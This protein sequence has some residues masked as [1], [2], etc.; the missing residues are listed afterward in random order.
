VTVVQVWLLVGVP[1]L[2]A[3]LA[4]Y[5]ARS[6]ALGALGVLLTLAAAAGVALVDQASAMVLGIVGVLLYAS[7]RAGDGAAVGDDP[8]R[9][10]GGATA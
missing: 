2:V 1:V 10:D 4:L 8:V 5:T 7:G 3:A 9:P 6:P